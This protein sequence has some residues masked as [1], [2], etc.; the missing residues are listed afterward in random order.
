[1]S[2]YLSVSK[3]GAVKLD[4]SPGRA[5]GLPIELFAVAASTGVRT[6]PTTLTLAGGPF[7]AW[8]QIKQ[9]AWSFF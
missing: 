9:D 2:A 7:L 8:L 4:E 3:Y 5:V 1:L 6:P